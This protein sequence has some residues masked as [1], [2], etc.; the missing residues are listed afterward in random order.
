MSRATLISRVVFAL[1]VI[2]TFTAFFV[3]QRLK[4][5]DPLVYAVNVKKYVSPND[6]DLRDRA[7]LR[8]R[9]KEADLVTVDLVDRAQNVVRTLAEDRELKAGPHRFFWNGRDRDGRPVTDGAYRVRI[10]M[11]RSGR[12]FI[13]DKFFVVD[14]APPRL[15]ADVVGDHVVSAIGGRPSRVGVRFSGV[16]AT[17]RAE[18][19]V[20]AVRGQGTAA[21]P[22]ASFVSTRG[23]AEGAWDLTVGGFRERATPCFGRLKTSGRPRP[24][25]PGGYV[26]A[27]RS[28]DAAG[29]VGYSTRVVPPR[30]GSIRGVAGVTLRGVE[31]APA[32]EPVRPGRRAEIVVNPPPGGYRFRLR[33]ADG[34]TVARGES[35]ART[36]RFMVPNRP[37]GLYELTV[38]A[39]RPSFGV[40]GMARGPVVIGER[41]AAEML[42]A[43]PA[44]AWQVANPVDADGDGFG[45]GYEVLPPGRQVRVRADRTL[46]GGA[47]PA[48]FSERERPIA[49]FIAESPALSA[50]AVTDYQLAQ[51]PEALLRGR[52]AVLFAGDERWITPQLGVALRAFVEGG[53]R[54][55]FFAPD[56]F[57]RTVRLAAGTI[58]GPSRRA[59][60]DIFGESVDVGRVAPA[61]L[62]AFADSLGLFRG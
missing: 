14:T 11:S 2:A 50:R 9:T 42:I 39:R 26:I 17:R 40:R 24:A 62:I 52:E 58:G 13:P 55:A 44:I 4:S 33:G 1:L 18:F 27:V 12:T 35:R 16:A 19:L 15:T 60:R 6:D 30:V 49:S 61:P 38:I 20:Y 59:E 53:G 25:P 10:S 8:F 51:N 46:A 36:L 5:A 47:L 41:A 22:V 37:Q 54:V 48:G 57:R 34:S 7:R 43:Y 3:A 29:N 45:D 32:M 56:A 23:K 31:I 28:C 21:R